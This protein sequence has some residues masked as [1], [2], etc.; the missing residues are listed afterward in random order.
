MVKTILAMGQ[1]NA[2]GRTGAT[3]IAND[4]SLV[5]N[6]QNDI[7]TL[8][9][10]GTAFIVPAVGANPF[11]NGKGSFLTSVSAYLG[12]MTDPD[13]VHRII[14]IATGGLSIDS[15]INAS[16]VK[17]PMWDRMK[18]ILLAAGVTQVDAFLWHQGE[19]D[20]ATYTTYSTRFNNL[21][22]A[23]QTDGHITTTTPVVIGETTWQYPNINT[24]LRSIANANPRVEIVSIGSYDSSDNT[25]FD[26]QFT[27]IIAVDYARALSR[28]DGSWKDKWRVADVINNSPVIANPITNQMGLIKAKDLISQRNF[29]VGAAK[30]IT[31]PTG[32]DTKIPLDFMFGNPDFISSGGGFQSNNVEGI[33]RFDLQGFADKSARVKLLD[34]TGKQLWFSSYAGGADPVGNNPILSGFAFMRLFRS[35]RVWLGI[36]H[37]KGTNVVHDMTTAHQFIRFAATFMGED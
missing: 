11:V 24:S 12:R 22:S 30:A 21:L 10:V 25:H 17:G 2:L 37:S 19:N 8:A 27:P 3:N 26:D 13:E 1:S 29:V 20:E 16:N 36:H 35:D 4:M 23:L 34:D 9:N 6:N 5:W 28:L 14:L 18:A 7:T 31:I 32:I 33:W 15:W